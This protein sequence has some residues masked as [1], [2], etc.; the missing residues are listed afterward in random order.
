MQFRKK[1]RAMRTSI[2]KEEG[3]HAENILPAEKGIFYLV[4]LPSDN[5]PKGIS[6]V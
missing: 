3:A 4:I 2:R 1:K 6:C 5:W